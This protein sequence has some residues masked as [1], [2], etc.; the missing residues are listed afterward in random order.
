MKITKD[1][2]SSTLQLQALLLSMT[3]FF[4]NNIHL[5]SIGNN[6]EHI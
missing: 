4:T 6:V 5:Y 1:A 2:L 3:I